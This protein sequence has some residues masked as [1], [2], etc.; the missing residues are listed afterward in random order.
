MRFFLAIPIALCIC[1]I[2]EP[3]LAGLGDPPSV[4]IFSFPE[5][6][7]VSELSV[8]AVELFTLYAEVTGDFPMTYK[9]RSN[10]DSFG[11]DITLDYIY[12]TPGEYLVELEA[13]D[14]Y[15]DI[16]TDSCIVNVVGVAVEPDFWG[17]I[18]AQFKD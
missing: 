8:L 15:G 3:S 11:N 5:M 10:G 13:T 9:W 2:P 14:T 1:L 17:R 6:V 7:E 16:G 18:K 12:G 4:H